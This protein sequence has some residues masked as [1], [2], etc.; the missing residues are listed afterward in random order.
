MSDTPQEHEK[1]YEE[2]MDGAN[3][4]GSFVLETE[5]DMP[6]IDFDVSAADK[7]ERNKMQ[8][9]MPD[10]LLE[11]IELP[12]NIDDV[13]DI[14]AEDIDLSNIS[15]Q[16]MTFGEEAT[17][18]WLDAIAENFSHEYYTESEIWNIFNRLDDE[19]FVSA[20]SYIIEL[21]QSS[22]PVTGFRRE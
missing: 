16:D 22:G 18:V 9:M 21:G 17:T 1:F 11:G 2:L 15:I 12:E 8:R 5:D 6:D 20:G 10:G 4:S 14:S 19:F 3:S 13:D 7:A